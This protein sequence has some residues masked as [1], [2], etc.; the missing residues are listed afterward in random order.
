MPQIDVE[1]SGADGSQQHYSPEA[2]VSP[3]SGTRLRPSSATRRDRTSI[4]TT[5]ST[6]QDTSVL[7]DGEDDLTTPV[8][9]NL[10]KEI[11]LKKARAKADEEANLTFKPSMYT[12]HH[13]SNSS[14]TKAPQSSVE[15]SPREN[16][17]DKLYSDA[18][19]RHLSSTTKEELLRDKELTFT[20][21]L[22][23]RSSSRQNSRPS[24]RSKDRPTNESVDTTIAT[25]ATSA[26]PV[27][28]RLSTPTRVL[29][30]VDNSDNNS[31][32]SFTPSISKRAKS[33]E[34]LGA[35]EVS[36]RLYEHNNT[37]REKIEQKKIEY[38]QKELEACTFSPQLVA[39]RSGS[40]SRGKPIT[41]TTEP[42]IDRVTKYE[43]NKKKKLEMARRMKEQD[44][45]A[46][47]T[48]KPVLV[49]N[50]RPS[51]PTSRMPVHERLAIPMEKSVSPSVALAYEEL[52]FQPKLIAKR[53]PTSVSLLL[54]ITVIVA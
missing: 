25:N 26:T 4:G 49:T 31:E 28:E 7:L 48:F 24:S 53:G 47:A 8:K 5:S 41:E 17:F 39:K 15:M 45:I 27:H 40:A 12:S 23:S 36:R 19:K 30:R 16:R 20:P 22:T 51:T 54:K 18:L 46:D 3:N 6:A 38:Q 1:Q 50:K 29:R 37:A 21:K 10:R 34:R 11:E 32:F 52:T 44:E 13:K 14:A 33:I 43:E 2:M 42:L 9:V 35:G